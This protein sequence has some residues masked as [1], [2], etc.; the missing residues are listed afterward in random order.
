MTG[1][2]LSFL[3]AWFSVI[4]AQLPGFQDIVTAE[5]TVTYA[6]Y[7]LYSVEVGFWISPMLVYPPGKSNG[8]AV[9]YNDFIPLAMCWNHRR[10]R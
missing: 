9:V 3:G 4:S 1:V 8:N 7:Y 2:E 10:L 6:Y 5:P